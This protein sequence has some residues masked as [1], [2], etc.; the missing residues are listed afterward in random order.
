M[1]DPKEALTKA[2]AAKAEAEKQIAEAEKAAR[3]AAAEELLS[4]EME[5]R[6]KLKSYAELV[7]AQNADILAIKKK[8]ADL[9]IFTGEEEASD[10]PTSVKIA[11]STSPKS[12]ILEETD[13][14][15]AFN[16]DN[17]PWGRI[18]TIS[19]IVIVVCGFYIF[20]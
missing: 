11:S 5:L 3:A 7:S 12:K 9:K 19:L 10:A 2:K 4:L 13:E 18:V 6:R 15:E 17:L 20:K 14:D 16:L 1:S 8:I